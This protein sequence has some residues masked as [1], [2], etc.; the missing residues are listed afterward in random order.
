MA[1]SR[2]KVRSRSSRVDR[3]KQPTTC[4]H[5]FPHRVTRTTELRLS[6]N[7]YR[8][9]HRFDHMK[10]ASCDASQYMH[11]AIPSSAK[12]PASHPTYSMANDPVHPVAYLTM[13][14]E[15]LKASSAFSQRVGARAMEGRKLT[16]FILET[17]A[18]KSNAIREYFANELRRRKPSY[19]PAGF[20]ANI[21]D[22][23]DTRLSLDNFGQLVQYFEESLTFVGLYGCHRVLGLHAVLATAGSYYFII[24]SLAL[25]SRHALVWLPPHLRSPL[26]LL[27]NQRPDSNI[28]PNELMALEGH[29]H[30]HGGYSSS[31]GEPRTSSFLSGSPGVSNSGQNKI[32]GEMSTNTHRNQR[33]PWE[34]LEGEFPKSPQLSLLGRPHPMPWIEERG[35]S[36]SR[37]SNQMDITYLIA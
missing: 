27:E 35:T 6:D 33:R 34:G 11:K 26:I 19:L 32:S 17:E 12:P 15:V 30:C 8:I 1:H 10:M 31:V 13:N 21:Q 14:M 16:D 18:N 23:Q 7:Q 22:K 2:H 37:Q 24:V 9:H 36:L 4:G 25:P 20:S 3:S 29:M 5:G 28:E